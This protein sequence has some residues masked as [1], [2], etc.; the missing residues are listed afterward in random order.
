MSTLPAGDVARVPFA[1]KLVSE[2]T[3]VCG[4][5]RSRDERYRVLLPVIKQG[6][7]RGDKAYHVVGPTQRAEHSRR[8]ASVGID[9]EEAQAEGRLEMFDWEEAYLPDG[10]FDQDRTLAAW[11]RTFE[12]SRR[13]GYP[14]TRLVAHMEWALQ[15][16]PGVSDLLEYEA[17][18]NH[19][20]SS[21]PTLTICS[22]DLD[23]FPATT[24]VDVLR[25]HPMSLI[26]GVLHENPFF[27]P[28][29]RFLQEL[30]ERG[31]SS[32]T[33]TS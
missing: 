26:G 11:E 7:E 25:T 27:V 20:Y 21:Y 28:P 8:L 4:F 14:L 16:R 33:V 10:R 2:H 18:F 23:E 1:G 19:V 32:K 17:R 6:F 3:H 24:I 31:A 30:Q 29:A 13:A 12:K 9:A 15:D 5:F 22:Y